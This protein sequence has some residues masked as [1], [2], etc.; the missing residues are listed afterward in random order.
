MKCDEGRPVCNRC[1][2]SGNICAG[3][4]F[5]DRTSSSTTSTT[6]TVSPGFQAP[7]PRPVDATPIEMMLSNYL[8]TT[9]STDEFNPKFWNLLLP[10][11]AHH[12]PPIWHARSSLA[13]GRWSTREC[14][15]PARG[16][17]A[18]QYSRESMRQYGISVKQVLDMTN[19]PF[20]SGPEKCSILL[21]NLLYGFCNALHGD[22]A[23]L[24]AMTARI[25]G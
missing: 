15:D 3:Y 17:M 24:L 10:Q 25:S 12:L 6:M 2:T 1:I 11:A 7:S 4:S 20:L 13:A 5:P 8:L 16:A 23:A 22:P 18:V 21:A 14:A 19:N 9:M